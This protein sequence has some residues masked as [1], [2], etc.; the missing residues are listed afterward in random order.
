[1]A[2]KT[3]T[4]TRAEQMAENID[5]LVRERDEAQA[6]A[7]AARRAALDL[8]RQLDVADSTADNLREA[9]AE[10]AARWR[11]RAERWRATCDRL[12]F[13]LDVVRERDELRAAKGGAT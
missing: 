2:R 9:L 11:A 1:M 7:V 5:R 10:H 8:A 12:R 4:K 6:E 13:A 3:K